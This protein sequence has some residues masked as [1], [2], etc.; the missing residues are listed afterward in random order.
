ML[1]LLL[2]CTCAPSGVLSDGSGSTSESRRGDDS[3]ESEG[4]VDPG[5]PDFPETVDVLHVSLLPNADSEYSGTD[6]TLTLCLAE[7]RCLTLAKPDW[8][9]NETG[10]VD[11]HVG[12]D[13]GLARADIAGLSWTIDDGSDQY[14]PGCMAISL[15]G[16][17][18]HCRDDYDL[19]LGT[20]DDDELPVLNEDPVL[21]CLGCWET[22]LTH[23][24]IVSYDDDGARFWYRTDATRR[25]VLHVDDQPVHIAYPAASEDFAQ[26][27]FVEGLQP[28]FSY[29]LEIAGVELGP[30]SVQAPTDEL[31]IAFGSCTKDDE[32]PIFSAIRTWGP[33]VFLFV[34]DNHYANSSDL[35][36]LR[37]WYRWAHE[38]AGRAELMTEAS[39]LATWDDHDYVGNNTDASDAGGD[40]AKRA[41]D[42]YWLNTMPA[43]HRIGD[44]EVFLLD[45]RSHRGE[46]DTMLGAEQTTWLVERLHDSE[47]TWKLVTNGSQFTQEGSDDSWAAFEEDFAAFQ[48]RVADVPGMVFLSGDIHRSEFRSLPSASY[49]WPELTSSP[50]A[51]WNSP[52]QDESWSV[53]EDDGTF[54]IGLVVT[55]ET[56]VA[57]MHAEDGSELASWTIEAADLQP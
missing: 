43:T 42:E 32:Q 20:D 41:F 53:C 57:T 34:G 3:Q 17:P 49:D 2:S 35:G 45:G 10:I 39:V 7:E 36:A 30:W 48:E 21:D 51:T 11:V 22:P 28:P 27:V 26:E 24:P 52:C 56:L 16:E 40:T 50:M 29:R 37:Q 1:A 46:D 19:K 8:N 5:M 15:D 44:V 9:D 38:R 18:L 14:R 55:P 6:D 31:R 33:D 54:F 25:S 23:G 12:E 4:V 13:F 47:A